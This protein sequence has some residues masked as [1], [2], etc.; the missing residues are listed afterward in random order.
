MF[1]KKLFNRKKEVVC[2]WLA[3][4]VHLTVTPA[5]A[6]K[7]GGAYAVLQIRGEFINR[8]EKAYF[9]TIR[10]LVRSLGISDEAMIRKL[11]KAF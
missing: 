3:E 11:S 4:N 9:I 8:T 7:G 5:V 6:I 2:V 10:D 1:F